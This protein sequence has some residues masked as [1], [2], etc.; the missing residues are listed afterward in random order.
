MSRRAGDI[1]ATL[2]DTQGVNITENVPFSKLTTWKAGGPA[3]F[4]VDVAGVDALVTILPRLREEGIATFVLGNGSNL[5]V[6]DSGFDGAVLRLRGELASLDRDGEVIRAGAGAMLGT[7]VSAAARA[8]LTGLEFALGIPGTVGGAVMTNA[9]TRDGDVA[10]VITVVSAV[11]TD[12]MLQEFFEF[13]GGYRS[14]LVPEGNVVTAAEFRLHEDS[15]ESIKSRM[16]KA[17]SRREETQPLGAATA[18]SVFKNPS[19]DSAGRLI[20]ECG[21]KGL[22]IGAASVAQ[23]HANFIVNEGGATASD[24]WEIM[25]RIASD[26]EARFGVRLE[27]EVRLIGFDKEL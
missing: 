16:H 20:D 22:R 25:S 6:S 9:G 19:G 18:G 11:S 1:I 2:A 17:R 27:P 13:D 15:S 24:I 8:D 14:P 21:L 5:L 7:A 12:G 26:V 10:S 3:R 23:A 4:L